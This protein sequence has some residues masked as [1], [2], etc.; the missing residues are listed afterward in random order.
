MAVI[1]GNH[2][3]QIREGEVESF[4]A[5]TGQVEEARSHL[6]SKEQQLATLME[7]MAAVQTAANSSTTPVASANSLTPYTFYNKVHEVTP[8]HLRRKIDECKSFVE[9]ALWFCQSF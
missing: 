9:Q 4:H 7:E 2:Q 3:F 1:N 5:L 6:C 8:R